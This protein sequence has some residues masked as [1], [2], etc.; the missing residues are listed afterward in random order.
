MS[1]ISEEGPKTPIKRNFSLKLKPSIDSSNESQNEEEIF[2]SSNCLLIHSNFTSKTNSNSNHT[3]KKRNFFDSIDNVLKKKLFSSDFGQNQN[4]IKKNSEAKS[5]EPTSI[6][7]KNFHTPKKR[8]S[9]FKLV[10]KGK[11]N[12]KD[13]SIFFQKT[14]KEELPEKKERTDIYGNVISKKNK[15]NVKVSFI[16][17]VTRQ[18]L[19]N[20][21][22]IECFKNIIIYMV[23]RKKKKLIKLQNG[24][25]VLFFSF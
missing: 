9:I 17:K 8:F 20:V 12:K 14:E 13:K 7:V 10:E 6:R 19:A 4:L 1:E 23:Y 2:F 25:A 3:T 11:K 18:P 5:T 21:V 15:K 24:N 16:D 22:E